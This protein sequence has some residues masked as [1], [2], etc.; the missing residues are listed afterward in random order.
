MGES[1]PA[2][3]YNL[4][5]RQSAVSQYA[6]AMVLLT[7]SENQAETIHQLQKLLDNRFSHARVLVRQLEQGP[8]FDAPIEARLFGPDLERLQSLGEEL[9]AILVNTPGVIHTRAETGD[10]LPKIGISVDEDKAQAAGLSLTDIAIQLNAA[11]EGII[12]G[13][14]IEATEELPVRVRLDHVNRNDLANLTS[15]DIINPNVASDEAVESR[16]YRGVPIS[17]IAETGLETEYGSI[18]HLAG[19]RMNELQAFLPAGVLP[20]TVL[21]SIQERLDKPNFQSDFRPAI[22]CIS[23]ENRQNATKLLTT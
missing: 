11:T 5:P 19:Q 4:I 7:T 3:Y 10:V 8:P 6:Q 22:P 12:G 9:R 15:I 13:S 1:A 17:A 21:T 16:N 14:V 20:S 23:E 18:T 2:F